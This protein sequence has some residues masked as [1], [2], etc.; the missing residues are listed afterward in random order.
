MAVLFELHPQRT[1][2][3]AAAPRAG[4]IP[5]AF[6]A[7]TAGEPSGPYGCR[8]TTAVDGQFVHRKEWKER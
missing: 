3:A 6:P 5:H 4:S 8:R 7:T 1:F 2:A